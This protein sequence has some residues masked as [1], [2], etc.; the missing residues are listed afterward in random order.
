VTAVGPR[1]TIQYTSRPVTRDTGAAVGLLGV[2][3]DA[4]ED[5]VA[6]M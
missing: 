6:Y 2:E 5:I 1:Y 4:Q 3:G